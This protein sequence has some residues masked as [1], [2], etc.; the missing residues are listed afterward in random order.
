MKA[1]STP[2]A[3]ARIFGVWAS[4]SAR[5]FAHAMCNSMHFEG[6]SKR[7][8]NKAARSGDTVAYFVVYVRR[9]SDRERSWRPFSASLEVKDA[10]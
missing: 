10:G 9:R 3:S 7:S 8:S 2:P 1:R 6:R 5:P 4:R